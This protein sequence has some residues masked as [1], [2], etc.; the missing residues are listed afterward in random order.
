MQRAGPIG[1]APL[2]R[3]LL[4]RTGS[5]LFLTFDYFP[6]LSLKEGR[7]GKGKSME[8]RSHQPS[9]IHVLIIIQLSPLS[10]S[11]HFGDPSD[12]PSH[13][14]S[15]RISNESSS[16]RTPSLSH[17]P[18]FIATRT[19]QKKDFKDF[20]LSSIFFSF[21]SFFLHLWR[22]ELGDSPNRLDCS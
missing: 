21:S 8:T 2:S 18:L 3:A 16:E 4:V 20:S 22:E 5:M 10:L 9:V 14:R 1:T 17:P 15:I 13:V 6:P 12:A 19:A 7:E 11:L